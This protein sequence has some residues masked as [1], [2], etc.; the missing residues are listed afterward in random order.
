MFWFVISFF[1]V[2]SVLVFVHELGHFAVARWTGVRVEEFGFGYPPRLVTLGRW[3]ETV[4]SLNAVPFGGFA[5]M[6]AEDDPNVPGGFA[7]QT[8]RVRLAVLLAGATMN[9]LLAIV[10][11]AL[12]FVA[13]WPQPTEF[14]SVMIGEVV[15]GAPASLAGLRIGDIVLRVDDVEMTSPKQLSEYIHQHLGQEI[16]FVVKRGTEELKI[17]VTPR[18]EWPEGQGPV[19]IGIESVASKISLQRY[20]PGQAFLLGAQEAVNIVVQTV[21]LPAALLRK[22]IPLEWARPVGPVAIARLASDAVEQSVNTGWWFPILRL[23]GVF[24]AALAISNLLPIPGLDG[25][26]ILFVV[27]EAIRGRRLAPEKEGVI[28]LIGLVVLVMVMLLITYQDIIT[29]IPTFDW[30]SLF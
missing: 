2:L 8:K 30:S 18:L 22:A 1:V 15:E 29:P 5:R 17:P 6:A 25:G 7:S 21:L 10:F 14:K 19:G 24:S 3:G 23:L 27:V 26:R 11:F 4:F 16:V 12:G 20:P 13:G 28:H 9:F